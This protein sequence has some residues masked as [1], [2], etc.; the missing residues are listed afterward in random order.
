MDFKIITTAKEPD[1]GKFE[2]GGFAG[3]EAIIKEVREWG[4]E[5]CDRLCKLR[6]ERFPSCDRL[7]KL[8]H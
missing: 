3:E 4:R 8:Q 6:V 5:I 7:C 1:F 2:E